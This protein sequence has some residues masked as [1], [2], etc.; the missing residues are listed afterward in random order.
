MHIVSPPAEIGLCVPRGLQST[1][2]QNYKEENVICWPIKSYPQIKMALI[3]SIVEP[4]NML[5]F[6]RKPSKKSKLS[7]D[8]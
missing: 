5:K 6:F 8:D 7:F 4:S 3:V 2:E 1:A